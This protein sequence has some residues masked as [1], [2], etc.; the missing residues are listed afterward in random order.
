MISYLFTN[1][2][3]YFTPILHLHS[4][5]MYNSTIMWLPT[6]TSLGYLRIFHLVFPSV[7]C[8][9]ASK[10]L[11]CK[12][13]LLQC[14]FGLQNYKYDTIRY[15][16]LFSKYTIY[17]GQNT[18]IA[19]IPMHTI[20]ESSSLVTLDSLSIPKIRPI[21]KYNPIIKSILNSFLLLVDPE[22]YD[23]P[24]FRL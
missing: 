11:A 10:T 15:L 2:K 4:T 21:A 3:H 14:L 13:T 16:S 17:I 6:L 20:E 1:V 5:I 22:G 7:L 23:P 18:I 24:T 9:A 8:Y 12:E 19:V